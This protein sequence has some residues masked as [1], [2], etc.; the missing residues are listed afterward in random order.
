MA[1]C[2]SRAILVRCDIG[3]KTGGRI[4]LIDFGGV[5]AVVTTETLPGTTIV[6]TFG[7]MAPEQFRGAAE[8]ASDL[9]SLGATLLYI[10]SG[11]LPSAFP[12][13]RM[14]L[15]VS[16]VSMGSRLRTVVEGLLEPVVEDRLTAKQAI[17]IL[18]GQNKGRKESLS[19]ISRQT[20][21]MGGSVFGRKQQDNGRNAVDLI[22]FGLPFTVDR[23]RRLRKPVGSRI[24]L[25]RQGNRLIIDIPPAKFDGTSAATGGFALVWNSFVAFWTVSA[26]AAGGVLFALFSL[27]FWFVGIGLLRKAFGRQLI[28]ERIE[29]GAHRWTLYQKLARIR[30]GKADWSSSTGKM[31]EGNTADLSS[32]D[33]EIVAYV[34]GVP[35]G[36][37]QLRQGVEKYI[38]GE[39]LDPVEQEW[40]VSVINSHLEELQEAAA[41]MSS[42]DEEF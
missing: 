13:T 41:S 37:L 25:T 18:R 8:P 34:N 35:Q 42:L 17:R 21:G 27:P 23:V 5:Q 4:Y 22:D 6:G 33:L 28:Q 16:G 29:I 9:Y 14:R 10:I 36:Q 19:V 15:D 40:L 38:F 24:T 2:I 30:E 7:F 1:D 31:A 32:A 26:L 20:G 11:R 3:G 39:G 12:T